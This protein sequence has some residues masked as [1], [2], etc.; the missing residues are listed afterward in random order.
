MDYTSYLENKNFTKSSIKSHKYTVTNFETWQTKQRLPLSQIT[1]NDITT[2][3]KHLKSKGNKQRTIQIAIGKLKHYINYQKLQGNISN[4]SITQ[5]KIQGVKR[6]SLYDILKPE[7]L[8]YIYQSYPSEKINLQQQPLT[9]IQ[10]RNKII[11]SLLIYQGI[12]TTDLGNLRIEHIKLFD[13]KIDIPETRK[14]NNRCLKLEPFQILLFQDYTLTAREQILKE[15]EKETD[16]FIVSTGT[17]DKVLNL[18]QALMNQIKKDIPKVKNVKQIRASVITN[19]LKQYNLRETQY[20]AG[21]R[22]VSSTESYKINDIESLQND[23]MQF[24]PSI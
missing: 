16:K 14:S 13:G 17:S 9:T 22:F 23:I 3:I 15:A 20:R 10:K 19:W 6:Q 5:L 2:Y 24:S 4:I 12:T 21:H 8:E 7:E 1:Y 18:L 11:L